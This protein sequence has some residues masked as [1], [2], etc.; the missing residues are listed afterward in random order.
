MGAT[1]E[2]F[3]VVLDACGNIY[4]VTKSLPNLAVMH[5]LTYKV[6]MADLMKNERTNYFASSDNNYITSTTT[7]ACPTNL[8]YLL[9]MNNVGFYFIPFIN[10]KGGGV[11]SES[12][13]PT[14]KEIFAWEQ[15]VGR[16]LPEGPNLVDFEYAPNGSFMHTSDDAAGVELRANFHGNFVCKSPG[17]CAVIQ[18]DDS[19]VPKF[20]S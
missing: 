5:P 12:I 4:S 18:L 15:G 3:D 10:K 13:T 17:T 9:D 6:V 16:Y 1:D 14:P 8:I 11:S 2:F 19:K 20:K 7:P